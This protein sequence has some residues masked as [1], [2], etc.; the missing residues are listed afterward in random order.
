[1]AHSNLALMSCAEWGAA[2]GE[3]RAREAAHTIAEEDGN[4]V[5][6]WSSS[7]NSDVRVAVLVEVAVGVVSVGKLVVL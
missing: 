5:A 2:G 7:I 3:I 6:R 1:M 4:N